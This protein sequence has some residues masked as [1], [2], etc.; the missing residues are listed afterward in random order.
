MRIIRNVA[1][2]LTVGVFLALAIGSSSE[3]KTELEVANVAPQVTIGATD[4]FADYKA[5]EIAAD[6]KYKGR[7]LQVT[8]T[9]DS[10]AKDITGTMYVTLKGDEF[11]GSIQ[12]LF[13]DAHANQLAGLQRGMKVSVKGKCGGKIMNVLL[14][15]CVLVR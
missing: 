15:G 10:I 9:V 3:K 1:S 8:G 11:I 12:C 5:N 2:A 7:V 14:N 6:Q 4:L 13:D